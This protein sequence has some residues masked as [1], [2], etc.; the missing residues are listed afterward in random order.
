[1]VTLD[2]QDIIANNKSLRLIKNVLTPPPTHLSISPSLHPSIPCA[3]NNPPILQELENLLEK[4]VITDH[5]FD[6]ISRQLP[7]ESSLSGAPTP[8][9]RNSSVVPPPGPPPTHAMANLALH[10]NA[11]PSPAPPAYNTTG[12]PA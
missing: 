6:S 9:S 4:G 12:P 5:V 1:M 10:Q 8:A 7:A 3:N 2:R 11:S